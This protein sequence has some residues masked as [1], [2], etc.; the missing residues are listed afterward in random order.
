VAA[1]A[2]SSTGAALAATTATD[3]VGLFDVANTAKIEQVGEISVPTST[4]DRLAYAPDRDVL[5]MESATALTFYDV[6]N[7]A[8]PVHL[9]TVPNPDD[10]GLLLLDDGT[11]LSQT[12]V[13]PA[14]V[15]VNS[16]PVPVIV[17]PLGGDPT[18]VV[19]PD[20]QTLAAVGDIGGDVQLWDIGIPS[21]PKLRA[22]LPG[23]S[24][25]VGDI[26]VSSDGRTLAVGA[27]SGVTQLWSLE[28]ITRP[29]L[30]DRI[31]G[32]AAGVDAVAFGS[33]DRQLVVVSADPVSGL[34]NGMPGSS[35]IRTWPL[36]GANRAA[37][38]SSI[39]GGRQAVPAWS[40][41]GRSVIGGF[42]AR[43]WDLHD[44]R[45]P[46]P[47]PPLPTLPIGGGAVYAF[48][49][50]A[51][52]VVSGVPVI[53]WDISDPSEPRKLDVE[54]AVDWPA[55]LAIFSPGGSLIATGDGTISLW[56]VMGSSTRLLAELPESSAGPHSADFTADG[57]TLVA[58]DGGGGANVW[59]LREPER[60]QVIARLSTPGGMSA[61][62]TDMKTAN[63]ITGD[64]RGVLA[65]WE[66]SDVGH[67]RELETRSAHAGPITGLALSPDGDML[68]TAGEDA[69]RLWTRD[70]KTGATTPV[71]TLQ[72]GGVYDGPALSFSP[73]GTLLAAAT[74]G[75]MQ[76]WDIDV[77][78][79]LS[80]LCAESE[81]ISESQWQEYLPADILYY[82]PCLDPANVT[83]P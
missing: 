13:T 58:L 1:A 10:G 64:R 67:P 31:P 2:F 61:L 4:L 16:L 79:L 21:S 14:G 55:S 12:R 35:L 51:D 59:D 70:P 50:G 52:V 32:V 29:I 41:D 36:L 27:P 72:A 71:A 62:A 38:T 42:P 22:S 56:S 5:T 23:E 40:P 57:A 8:K 49:P 78:R 68:A 3:R 24:F 7:P 73:D 54:S 33:R 25:L 19:T 48:Q 82:P 80:Q 53:R 47:G 17:T 66:I 26:A 45:Y 65:I 37:S 76:I 6:S 28:D 77:E 30:G 9:A 20:Q 46:S 43:L 69:V 83:T 81:T 34:E 15:D 39:D 74:S 63:L 60:P 75:E 11:L 44:P 18:T